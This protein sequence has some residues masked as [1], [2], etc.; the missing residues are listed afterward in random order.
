MSGVDVDIDIQITSI[1]GILNSLESRRVTQE[2]IPV[3]NEI[4]E[5]NKTIIVNAIKQSLSKPYCI[6]TNGTRVTLS[7]D[8]PTTDE[9][10]LPIIKKKEEIDD[11]IDTVYGLI[12]GMNLEE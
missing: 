3:L 9:E 12:W 4:E 2:D 1:K 7:F 11:Q 5:W 10:L 8:A 6:Q